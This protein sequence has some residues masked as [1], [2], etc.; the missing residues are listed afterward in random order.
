M[1]QKMKKY[2][3]KPSAPTPPVSLTLERNFLFFSVNYQPLSA[4]G[5]LCTGQN[6]Q[7]WGRYAEVFHRYAPTTRVFGVA[8]EA[9]LPVLA[10]FQSGHD[11]LKLTAAKEN[12]GSPT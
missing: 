2:G 9:I 4:L 12:G 6:T 11:Q 3:H 5:R 8:R 10:V 7:N 1:L